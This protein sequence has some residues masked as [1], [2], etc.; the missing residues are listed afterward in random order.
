MRGKL[1]YVKLS[2][3]YSI[4][5]MASTAASFLVYV[6]MG[7]MFGPGLMGAFSYAQ[8]AANLAGPFLAVGAEPV[9]VRELV[10][11][12]Q[13]A[14]TVLGSAYRFLFLMSLA[15]TAL[16][17]LLVWVALSNA[18]R[19]LMMTA[20]L[21]AP[22]ICNG[23]LVIDHYF[24]ARLMVRPLVTARIASLL[25]GL[26]VKVVAMYSGLSIVYV[27]IGFSLEQLALVAL[28]II[29]YRRLGLRIGDWRSTPQTRHLL[30]RQCLPS[31]L[32][33]V[34]VQL[35]FRLNFI[36]LGSL[37]LDPNRALNEVGQYAVAFQIVQLTNMLPLV[38]SSAI[39]PR[40]VTLH[41]ENPD[42]YRQVL[43]GLLIWITGAGYVLVL[44]AYFLG[45]PILHAVFGVKFDR[46]ANILVMLC[47]STVFNFSGAVRALF[48]NI[49]GMTK[50]HLFNAALGLAILAPADFIFIPASGGLG[51]AGAA[52]VATFVSGILSSLLLSRTR[53]F[54]FDQLRALLLYRRGPAFS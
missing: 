50:Y 7:R 30:L 37:F 45:P 24:R 21:V 9:V 22:F 1:V 8:S 44:G 51:A 4:E 39:Y 48:I 11:R 2:S 42:R 47:I 34:V 52:A 14:D 53:S 46:A 23:F 3:I 27:A 29:A 5:R 18:D 25:F 28:L 41:A 33:A 13:E 35:F 15:V 20:W 19:T 32:S 36:M 54:G 10:R 38:I 6:A 40:L 26:V 16:P 17:V 49:N 43:R 12:P 31:M